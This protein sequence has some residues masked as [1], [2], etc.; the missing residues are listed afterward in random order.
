MAERKKSPYEQ[1]LEKQRKQQENQTAGQASASPSAAYQAALSRYFQTNRDYLSDYERAYEKAMRLGAADKPFLLNGGAAARRR[2]QEPHASREQARQA[3]RKRSA[4]GA[5]GGAVGGAAAGIRK[6]GKGLGGV[7]AGAAYNDIAAGIR[8]TGQATREAGEAQWKAQAALVQT[9]GPQ[10]IDSG[11]RPYAGMAGS[12]GAASAGKRIPDGQRMAR[13]GQPTPQEARAFYAMAAAEKENIQRQWQEIYDRETLYAGMGGLDE[14]GLAALKADYDARTAEAEATM[15]RYAPFL[16]QEDQGS[17][18]VLAQGVKPFQVETMNAA[19]AAQS[20]LGTGEADREEYIGTEYMQSMSEEYIRAMQEMYAA[21]RDAA[22][23][24]SGLYLQKAREDYERAIAEKE[25]IQR[26][27]QEVYDRETMYAGM[28]GLDEAG[29]AALKADYDARMAEAD[30]AIDRYAAY[31]VQREPTVDGGDAWARMAKQT[32]VQWAPEELPDGA[33]EPTGGQ[34]EQLT[35]Q[36]AKERY[37]NAVAEKKNIQRQWQEVYDRETLYADMGGLDEAG[38]AALKAD[39]DARMAEAE[40][41]IARYEPYVRAYQDYERAESGL[42]SL[43]EEEALRAYDQSAMADFAEMSRYTDPKSYDELY[44]GWEGIGKMFQADMDDEALYNYVNSEAFQ[45]AYESAKE[46]SSGSESSYHQK[47]YHLLTEREKANANYLFNTNQPERAREYLR[48][49]EPR[50]QARR[51]QSLAGYQTE[52]G[53]QHPIL[54]TGAAAATNLSNSILTPAQIGMTALGIGDQNSVLF[55]MQRA[56]AALRQ[57]AGERIGQEAEKLLGTQWAGE[58]AQWLYQVGNSMIDSTVSAAIGAGLFG[59]GTKAAVAASQLIQSSNATSNELAMRLEEGMAPDKALVYAGLSGAIEAVTERWSIEE[60]MGDP[61]N[62]GL[63]LLKT[64]VSEGSEE[65]NSDLLSTLT[66]TVIA[67]ATGGKTDLEKAAARYEAQGMSAE[68]AAERALQDW[69]WELLSDTLAGGLSGL[70]SGV[71]YGGARKVQQAAQ[72]RQD[73]AEIGDAVISEGTV[74]SALDLAKTLPEGSRARKLAEK[75]EKRGERA[76]KNAYQV[77]ALAMAINEETKGQ[78][79]VLLDKLRD[80]VQNR[81]EK[82]GEQG[83]VGRVADAVTALMNGLELT[84]EQR[85]ALTASDHGMEVVGELA[86]QQRQN[87]DVEAYDQGENA[88]VLKG[89]AAVGDKAQVTVEVNGRQETRPLSGLDFVSGERGAAYAMAAGMETAEKG[90]AFLEAAEKSRLPLSTLRAMF[91]QVYQAGAEGNPL[92]GRLQKAKD[93]LG[94]DA[95]LAAYQAGAE[96]QARQS[97]RLAFDEDVREALRKSVA[98]LPTEAEAGYTGVVYKATR[99]TKLSQVKAAQVEL[100]HEAAKRYGL[101]VELVDTLGGA[102]GY[103]AGGNEMTIALDAEGGLLTR[104]FSHEA[105]HYIQKW[106]GQG[107]QDIMGFVL[108]RLSRTEGYDLAARVEETR[109]KYERS[110]A[111]R[112][113]GRRMTEQEAREEIVADSL[114]DVLSDESAIHDL[115]EQHETLGKK[116]LSFLKNLARELRDMARSLISPEA[117]AMAKQTAEDIDQL[118]EKFQR[119]MTVAA[120][121][122]ENG[123]GEQGEARYSIKEEDQ[124]EIDKYFARKIDQWDGSNTGGRFKLGSIRPGGIYE[125]VGLQPGPLYMD[126]NKAYAALQ[127]HSDHLNKNILKQVPGMLANPVVITEPIN[128]NVTNTVN[129]FGELYGENGKPIMVGLMVR[130]DRSGVNYVNM[131]RTMEMRRDANKLITEDTVLYL[132]PNKKR[133]THWFQGLWNNSVQFAGTQRHWRLGEANIPFAGATWGFIRKIAHSGANV[134]ENDKKFSLKEPVEEV[135]GLVAVHNLTQENLRDALRLGG[136]PMP[137]IAVVKASEGHSK[138][139]PISLVF[140][141]ESIDPEADARNKLYGSDAWTPTAKNAQVEYEVHQDAL[142]D[143]ENRIMELGQQIAGGAFTKSGVLRALGVE[144]QSSENAD[145]L[146]DRLARMEGVR[147]AYLADKGVNIE[148]MYKEKVFDRYGNESLGEYLEAAGETSVKEAAERLEENSQEVLAQEGERVRA[149]IRKAYEKMHRGFLDRRPE[150]KEKR[151]DSY[152]SER[153]TDHAVEEFI[154]HAAEYANNQ[155]ATSEE[156]DRGAT[157]DR[158]KEAAPEAEIRAWIRPMLD[159]VVGEKGIV[160]GKEIFDRLGNRKSFWQTHDHYTLESIV[161]AMKAA[162]EKGEGYWGV[163]AEGLAATASREYESIEQVRKDQGRLGKE[164]EEARKKR[165]KQMDDS[166]EQIILKVK[167][168]NRAHSDSSFEESEIIGTV[169]MQTAAMPTKTVKSIVRAFAKE[170]YTISNSLAGEIAALYEEAAELP[171]SYF[172]AKPRR[173][174]GF[175]EVKAAILPETETELTQELNKAGVRVVPYDGTDADRLTKLNELREVRFSLRDSDGNPV[176][177]TAGDIEDNKRMAANMEAVASVTGNRFAKNPDKDFKTMATEYFKE[178]GGKADNPILGQIMLSEKGIEHLIGSKLTNRKSALLPAVK[179]VIEQGH[180]IEIQDNH[181]G[182][183]FDTAL[184]AAPV[185]LDGTEYYMGVAIKQTDGR[186][187]QYYVHDAVVVQKKE[188]SSLKQRAGWGRD[189]ASV[190]AQ[191][192]NLSI[193]SILA[194][195]ADY[196]REFAENEKI[197]YSLKDVEEINQEMRAALDENRQ[198]RDVVRKLNQRLGAQREAG[199]AERAQTMRMIARQLRRKYS[200]TV[201]ETTLA[202]NLSEAFAAM[203]SAKTTGESETAMQ[204]MGDIA[205]DLLKNSETVDR[206]AYD[207]YKALRKQVKRLGLTETQWQEAASLFGSA[208]VFRRKMMG[209]WTPP[210]QTVTNATTLDMVWGDLCGQYP[211]FF[212]ADASEGDMVHQMLAMLDATRIKRHTAEEQGMNIEEEA[213]GVALEIFDE[214]MNMPSISGVFRVE[215][216]ELREEL[217]TVREDMEAALREAEEWYRSNLIRR[218]LSQA[219]QTARRERER[220]ISAARREIMRQ[221]ARIERKLNQPSAGGFVPVRM[222]E[223]VEALALALDFTEGPVTQQYAVLSTSTM[224][225]ARD[226]YKALATDAPAGDDLAAENMRIFYNGDLEITFNQLMD[227]A[228]GK[229]AKDLDLEELGMLRDI[230]GG[231]AAA[232]I[233]EDRLFNESQKESLQE[234]AGSLMASMGARKEH[235]T[236]GRAQKLLSDSLGRG[237]LKPV[238][239]FHQFKGTAMEG[240]WRNLRNAEGQHVRHVEAASE[241]LEKALQD[242]GM[243]RDIDESAKEARKRAEEIE[244]ESGRKVRLTDQELMTIYA[245]YKR[246]RKVGTQHLLKGGFLLRDAPRGSSQEPVRV[247]LG[248]IQAMGKRLSKQQIEYVDHMV[249]YLSTECAEWGNEVT[250]KLYGVEKFREDYYIPFS[251]DRNYLTSNPGQEQDQRLKMGSFT[252]ALTQGASSAI[253]IHPFTQLWCEHVEKMSDYNAFVLPIED[254]ARVMNYREEG[255]SVRALMNRAYGK[256]V[257]TYID[258]FLKNLNGNARASSGDTWL[259]KLSGTAKGAAVTFNLSVA[260]Q[261][262]GAGIRAAA[263]LDAK[264]MAIG[265]AKG[266]AHPGKS[267]EE[268]KQYAPV[269]VLKSWGYFDTQQARGLYDRARNNLR[270]KLN[271]AGG[272]L[273]EKGDQLNWAQIWEAC[274]AEQAELLKGKSEETIL[275]AAGERFTE[276]IDNTQVVDSIFQRALW[277]FEPGKVRDSLLNFMS[278]PITQYN[279]LY[280]AVWDMAEARRNAAPAQR[281]AATVKAARSLTRSVVALTAS[282]ALTAALKTVATALRD[283]DD[284]KKEER[285]GKQVIVG[286]RTYWDKYRENLGGNFIDSYTGLIPIYSDML[287]SVFSPQ[288]YGGGDDLETQAMSYFG[289]AMSQTQKL[290][291]GE[292]NDWGKAVYALTQGLSYMTGIGFSN[293]FRDLNALAQTVAGAFEQDVV[294]MQGTTVAGLRTKHTVAWDRSKDFASRLEVAKQ[295]YAYSKEKMKLRGEDVGERKQS[296]DIYKTLLLDAYYASGFGEEFQAAAQAAI[297]MGATA[298][299]LYTAFKNVLRAN[300]PLVQ[301]GVDALIAGDV[302]AYRAAVAEME[303]N[304]IGAKAAESMIQSAY[305]G[306][307]RAP[308]DEPGTGKELAEKMTAGLGE[309]DKTAAES[310]AADA[311]TAAVASGDPKA[312]GQAVAALRQSGKSEDSLRTR[313]VTEYRQGYLKAL[314]SGDAAAAKQAAAMMKGAGVAIGDDDLKA[315]ATGSYA[316]SQFYAAVDAGD[317][318]Q[319]IAIRSYIFAHEDAQGKR[320]AKSYLDQSLKSKYRAMEGQERLAFEKVLLQLGY[321]QATLELW[322]K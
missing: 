312:L 212:E 111:Y 165:L 146:A 101:R 137:S 93:A 272:F 301:Q 23:K 102:N 309:G 253:V 180:L 123:T 120:A 294:F 219:E 143:V 297:D 95:A 135:G 231:Y 291:N 293:G 128:P 112:R 133:T 247:T 158:M 90:Q 52:L 65:L 171:T 208:G 140:G 257:T 149:I 169:M 12:D 217:Q 75:M 129:V 119:E 6:A 194:S 36:E 97:K 196:K 113:D 173:A 266:T 38:L 203:A 2:Q 50:L 20:L 174:V 251:V 259:R 168:G 320:D 215:T 237:L 59:N 116:I 130:H 182:Y 105:Y 305:N 302:A 144:E 8:R 62:F 184:I 296:T 34:Q 124:L 107:A 282:G 104:T 230:V 160:N 118:R 256:Q 236:Q 280:R 254:M 117:K 63:Y 183:G 139:G 252:K 264:S 31:L 206:E 98:A 298:D 45:M 153:V 21:N 19:N 262:A 80:D 240:V 190:G 250:R 57:G 132:H 55:D 273:A 209:Q 41:D 103:Y 121:L 76:R 220:K 270:S 195:L 229:R 263:M 299:G 66:D 290:L 188:A 89:I 207:Q 279:M 308:A 255:E 27:W 70:G 49:L 318:Q 246:E 9:D 170:G 179:D 122:R 157:A 221:K 141:R 151:I 193:A 244:L 222:R 25:N 60:L 210:G 167:Q 96:A 178:I 87:L 44:G 316:R 150:L 226:A 214:Y 198:L 69:G 300:E 67:K 71:A 267:Y 271:D 73:R 109:R 77:G 225:Q 288:S 100:L 39:Y 185:L 115:M 311:Y 24:A 106:N 211:E 218:D 16:E 233:N 83:D 53:V 199:G 285:D 145:G 276:V 187:T 37:D 166:I 3:A 13:A 295:Y 227:R 223:A 14:A 186:N 84:Q 29:L 11:K 85:E 181:K 79:G 213:S 5:Y 72:A 134:N 310:M 306:A 287:T 241:Y 86:E 61:T 228:A 249:A 224:E 56:T 197:R 147:A 33:V 163:S 243:Q 74:Q 47:G 176:E 30:A 284:D 43:N 289:K 269:A 242:Y 235:V 40:A 92:A 275:K 322:R 99:E 148:P 317:I 189:T 94:P 136:M 10:Q 281:R 315:W 314:W 64:S 283:R 159:S 286:R 152:M 200:S 239:V 81:L 17:R 232:I 321:A 248:D 156:L 238:S 22:E 191:D 7:N 292:S 274:K 202:D 4:Q 48:A 277:A 304:G 265:T 46:G 125:G 261:Q 175:D 303:M 268:A 307:T 142:R 88:V 1:A 131:V 28:G 127:K 58:A 260:I 319:A 216:R 15:E 172:E 313:V 177:L 201:K 82:K 108:D 154:R 234:T 245:T 42:A 278:E 204:M 51:A 110:D 54:A 161:R 114:L 138:Y 78:A 91:N 18:D 192:G 162:D 205:L 126:V 32:G 68:A 26:Q 155:G 164:D 258:S 35:Y